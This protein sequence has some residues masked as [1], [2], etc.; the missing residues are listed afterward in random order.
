[1][2][3]S[4]RWIQHALGNE[5]IKD[6]RDESINQD[7]GNLLHAS[8]DA[9]TLQIA[10]DLIKQ[11]NIILL[12]S[13]MAPMLELLHYDG[14]DPETLKTTKEGESSESKKVKDDRIKR[15]LEQF[16]Y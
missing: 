8:Y 7:F 4:W 2:H 10:K 11:M 6:I 9:I 13:S 12:P 16:N 15:M 1:M 14:E 3:N 5:A